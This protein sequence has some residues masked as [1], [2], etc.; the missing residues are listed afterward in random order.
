VPSISFS[1]R[2]LHAF[3]GNITGDRR[4]F[5]AARN[6]VDFIDVDNA[7]LGLLDIVI[8]L[9][10]QLLDDILDVFADVAG[11]GQRG[12]IGNHERDIQLPRQG[13]RQQRLAG[14]GGADQQDV[15]LG[16][17]DFVVLAATRLAQTLV[18]VVHRHRQSPFGLRLTDDILI[19]H[20]A[21]FLRC[22]QAVAGFLVRLPCRHPRE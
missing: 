10:Q 16:Q 6:L 12:C 13:L 8:A 17:F 5:R 15:A 20:S 7:V 11:F 4:V 18:V 3:A 19:Q 2:L 21:D 1:K 14:T 9:L 22:R